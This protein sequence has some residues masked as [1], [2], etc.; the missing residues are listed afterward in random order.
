MSY[1]ANQTPLTSPNGLWATRDNFTTVMENLLRRTSV[2]NNKTMTANIA[3][4]YIGEPIKRNSYAGNEFYNSST[5][6]GLKLSCYKSHQFGVPIITAT[7]HEQT[8]EYSQTHRMFHDFNKTIASDNDCKRVTANA[9]FK[10]WAATITD[11]AIT[12]LLADIEQHYQAK[13]IA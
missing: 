6:F 11:E 4:S 8:S 2:L 9:L 3:I 12:Q 7:V 1:T 13:G 5:L 10:L